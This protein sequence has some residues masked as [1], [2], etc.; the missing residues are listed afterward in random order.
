MDLNIRP[1]WAEVD[2]DAIKFNMNAIKD[3]A[4]DK[5]II[6]VVKAD[7]YG[8]GAIDLA[9]TLLE[10][11]AKKFAVAVLTEALELRKN[12]VNI[13]IVILGYTPIEFATEL[14]YQDIEQTVTSL[15]YAINL[16]N[17]A[18][19]GKTVIPIHIA[20][21][22][23]MGRIGF[24]ANEKSINEIE[25]VSKL[26]NLK[27]VGIFSHF[28][29][30][31]ERD[32][33]YSEFQKKEFRD[34]VWQLEQRGVSLGQKHIYNSAAIVEF[35]DDDFD[36]IRPG[37]ILYGYYP[38]NEVNKENIKLKPALML[39]S[40]VVHIKTLPKGKYISYGRKFVT[41]KESV[42]A[43]LP[44]G[45]ADGYTRLLT[46]KAKVIINGKL[47]PVVGNICMDQCMIDVTEIPNVNIGDE[48]ILI[49]E[50]GNAKFNADDIADLLGTI[51]YEVICM[52]GKRVPRVYKL[53]GE[54][55]K[56]RNYI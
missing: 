53:N 39:K 32:K 36:A 29:T 27:I 7:A 51:N 11:G 46:N 16:N 33:E 14:L 28:A 37:I 43:T 47:A 2:L 40:N 54:I 10:C 48:V 49:G 44:I 5:D 8:H 9:P 21:D 1:V 12:N 42:I 52:I 15:E 31:D 24:L 30:A 55:I 41:E 6:A 19:E 25:E 18:K 17:I 56:T 13:P 45:Y 26:S 38:S 3:A 34:I 22:T 50:S 35:N 23:G 20:I 4:G